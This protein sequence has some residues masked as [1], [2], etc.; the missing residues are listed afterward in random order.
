MGREINAVK[1]KLCVY[2]AVVNKSTTL[3]QPDPNVRGFST[4]YAQAVAVLTT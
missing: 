4:E 2:A 1:A 3:P